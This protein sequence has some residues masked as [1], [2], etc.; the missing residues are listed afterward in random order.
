MM[1]IV[2]TE[3]KMLAEEVKTTLAALGRVVY[4]PFDDGRLFEELA[5]CEVLMVRL[6][7]YVGPTLL[8]RAPRLRFVLTATTGLDHIDIAATHAAGVRVISLRDCPDAIRDVSATAE[9]TWGLLLALVRATPAAAAHVLDGGWNRDCF[10]GTELRGKRLGIVGHGRIGAMVARIGSAFGMDVAACDTDPFKIV[11]P[12]V[13]CSLEELARRS[14]VLSIHV[15]AAPHNRHLISRA[16]IAQMKRSAVL[17]NTA[18]AS[19]VDEAALAEAICSGRLAGVAVDVL[20]GEEQGAVAS[21]PLLACARAGYNVLITPHVGGAAR[22]AIAQA[23]AAV[24]K[25]LAE[26]VKVSAK[27][28]ERRC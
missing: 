18:R 14:D 3:P 6:G 28:R 4:G 25:W 10:W 19:V 2:V 8:A 9:H 16:L 24:V 17:L 7:R 23:E 20:E 15:S 13:A 22:E 12:A 21:S 26:I 11:A 5:D 27:E 1:K